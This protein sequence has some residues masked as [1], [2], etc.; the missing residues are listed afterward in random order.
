MD[1]LLIRCVCDATWAGH[2]REGR[3]AYQ[4]RAFF[5]ADWEVARFFAV[6]N[7]SHDGERATIYW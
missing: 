4:A 6:S 2:H 7:L 5:A 1:S 3:R